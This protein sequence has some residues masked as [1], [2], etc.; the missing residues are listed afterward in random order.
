MA[1]IF[2]YAYWIDWKQ[3]QA[4]HK[5]AT[6]RQTAKETNTDAHISGQK[7]SQTK[8]QTDNRQIVS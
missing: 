3:G 6:E 8:R 1:R 2:G 5:K 4:F 7:N